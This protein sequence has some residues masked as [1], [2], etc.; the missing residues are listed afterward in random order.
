MMP[1][2]Q[3]PH[4]HTCRCRAATPASSHYSGCRQHAPMCTASAR[5]HNIDARG[6]AWPSCHSSTTTTNYHTTAPLGYHVQLAPMLHE[7]RT[8]PPL[9]HVRRHHVWL[10][11]KGH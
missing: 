8:R 2:V 4:R 3:P 11:S 9:S 7:Q 10:S 5:H 6:T 1:H